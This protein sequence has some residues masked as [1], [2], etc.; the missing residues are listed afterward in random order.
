MKIVNF[1]RGEKIKATQTKT[2]GENQIRFFLF[3]DVTYK[4]FVSIT[5]ND[6]CFNYFKV[7]SAGVQ[8]TVGGRCPYRSAF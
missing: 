2:N 5:E 3:I 8:H 1:I 6:R 7:L 4:M